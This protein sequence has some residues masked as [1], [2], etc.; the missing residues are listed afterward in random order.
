MISSGVPCV[1]TAPCTST[2]ISLREPENDV[3]VVLDD[4][5]R[6][7]RVERGHHIEDEMA[8]RR[9]HAGGRLVEQQHAR[10]L[11]E[12][13]G[14]F[15][16]PLAAIGQFAHQLQ[17]IVDQPQ[18]VEMIERLVKNDPAAADRPPHIVGMAVT[19]ADAHADVFQHR[20]PAEQLVDLEGAREAAP[21]AFGLTH[22]CDVLAVENH[23]AR[24]R[25][26]RAGDQ[27]HQ[28]RLA[29]AVGADERVPRAALERQIDIARHRQRAESPV[30]SLDLQ[31]SAHDFFLSE[32]YLP[33]FSNT[34]ST[35]RGV[36]STASTSIRPM[37]NCQKVGLNFE[38]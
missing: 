17:R 7:I 1:N 8:L 20:E 16:Q 11:R 34:P 18:R 23:A 6:D 2:V 31:R 36:N 3:H 30:Q 13:D 4:Q 38:K 19:L 29:G 24:V 15:H 37:P 9:R 27:V 35:P 28:R 14:D 10:L 12:R 26:E 21:R 25:L 33:M 5:H 22:V 32:K